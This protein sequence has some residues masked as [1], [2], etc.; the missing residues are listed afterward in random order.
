MI[1]LTY[2]ELATELGLK[3]CACVIDDTTSGHVQ[4]WVDWIL[5]DVHWMNRQVRKGGVY[6]FLILTYRSPMGEPAWRK[7]WKRNVFAFHFALTRL[8]MRLPAELADQDKAYVRYLLRNPADRP[9]RSEAHEAWRWA[10][11]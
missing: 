9:K 1:D 8:R 4:G 11:R 10:S 5:G 2:D 6:R 3:L 7:H